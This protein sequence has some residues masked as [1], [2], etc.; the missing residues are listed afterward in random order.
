MSE[1]VDQKSFYSRGALP[2][3]TKRGL[4]R[5]E[6]AAYIGISPTKFDEMVADGRMPTPKRIDAR[7]VWDVHQLDSFFDKLPGS[8]TV[9]D[10]PWD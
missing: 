4:S 9:T 3:P 10:N 7:R 5:D 8:E 6:A 1:H 2:V